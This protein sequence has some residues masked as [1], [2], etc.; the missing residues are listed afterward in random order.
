MPER[1]LYPNAPVVLVALEVRH[2]TADNLTPAQR[3]TIKRLI[4]AHAPIMKAGQMQQVT[5]V[6][7]GSDASV[8]PDVKIEEFPRYFSRDNTL[9][10]SLRSEAIVIE[11]TRYVGWSKLREVAAV[12]FQA[13]RETDGIDGVERI[14]LRYVDEIRAPANTTDENWSKWINPLLLGPSQIGNDLSIPVVQWEGF[15]AFTPGPERTLVLRYGPRE[16]Y[17]VDPGGDLKRPTPPP[18]PFF[19]VDMD[20]FWIPG[21]GIPVFEPDSVL[22]ICDELHGSVGLLFESLITDELRKEVFNAEES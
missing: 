18:G 8:V 10:V 16:G 15:S 7:S 21:Q 9:A 3:A 5:M 13:R 1:E 19:L 22:G 12:A 11:T 14:G 17:A 4:S 6:Q 2:P 20:S